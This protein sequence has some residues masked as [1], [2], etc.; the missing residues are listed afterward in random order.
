MKLDLD[1]IPVLLPASVK[2]FHSYI[3]NRKGAEQVG[4]SAFSLDQPVFSSETGEVIHEARWYASWPE[5][6]YR[7]YVPYPLPVFTGGKDYISYTEATKDFGFKPTH[8]TCLAIHGD[9]PVYHLLKNGQKMIG[10]LQA[11]KNSGIT[12]EQIEATITDR[13]TYNNW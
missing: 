13:A 7:V 4:A 3:K 2:H 9:W 12:S 5:K 6:Y 1:N 8:L 11:L 10:P